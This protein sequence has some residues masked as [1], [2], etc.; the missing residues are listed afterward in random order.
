MSLPSIF[1]KFTETDV[2]FDHPC[3]EKVEHSQDHA[4]AVEFLED[5]RH[6]D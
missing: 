5:L 3:V 4:S 2:M 1:P 6:I